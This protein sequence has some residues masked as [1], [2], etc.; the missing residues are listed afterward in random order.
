MTSTLSLANLKYKFKQMAK[1]IQNGNESQLLIWIIPDKLACSHRPLRHN[2]IYGGSMRFLDAGATNLLMDW[3][4]RIRQEGI[5]SIICLMSEEEVG[6][7]SKLNL[8][9]NNLLEFYSKEGFSVA[10]IP[11]KDPAHIRNDPE[12]LKRKTQEVCLHALE[13]FDAL[14][15]PILLHCSAGIDRSSPVAIHLLENRG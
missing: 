13:K 5:R 4:A 14:E 11:W 9:A 8:E 12:A 7:Y 2:P 10:S 15:K 3:I 1:Q 6:F